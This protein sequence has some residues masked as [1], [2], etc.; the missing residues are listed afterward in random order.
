MTANGLNA[1]GTR[2]Y[3][4]GQ[5]PVA[6]HKFQEALDRDPKNVDAQ[7]NLAAT[8]HQMGKVHSD[9]GMLAQAEQQYNYCLDMK[10][11]HADCYRGLAVLLVETHRPE[12]AFRLLK[13]W[14]RESPTSSDARIELARLFEEF[15]DKEAATTHLEQAITLDAANPRASRAW[16]ALAKLREESGDY[17]QALANYQ[18]SYRLNSFQPG[19]ATRIAALTRSANAIP[20]YTPPGGTRT[21]TTPISSSRY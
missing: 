13:G 2:L 18:R 16:A 19:V 3:Q 21:V 17:A 6:I 8:Y 1:D 11:D 4:Q 15:G 12:A 14:V 5:Y 10:C 9:P 7:Y 20:G